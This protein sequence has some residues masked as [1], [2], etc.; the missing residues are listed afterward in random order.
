MSGS[1]KHKPSHSPKAK[2]SDEQ[3]EQWLRHL[4]T[5]NRSDQ[6]IIKR[7]TD[8]AKAVCGSRLSVA[9]HLSQVRDIL[10]LD[11]ANAK[12]KHNWTLYLRV[13]LPGL[14]VSRSQMFRDILAWRKAEKTFPQLL[15]EEFLANG[16]ALTVR[17]TIEQPLGKM[18]EPIQHILTKRK[19]EALNGKECE[20]VL[21]E[22]AAIIKAGAKK[23][24][25]HKSAS[26]KEKRDQI[27]AD[28]HISVVSRIEQLSSTMEPGYSYTLSDIRSDLELIFSRIMTA[29][30]VDDVELEPGRLPE[31]FKRLSLPSSAVD[32]SNDATG[33]VASAAT[34]A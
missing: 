21:V 33:Q 20:T 18:T 24:R 9:K 34:A 2:T 14:A 7:E 12:Q 11:L 13:A 19:P 29:V 26:V 22:A 4:A 1:K 32:S 17:P 23:S 10:C 16:Y 27:Y 15:L 5:L 25:H 3:Q 31:G 6:E 8:A 30:G 28:V